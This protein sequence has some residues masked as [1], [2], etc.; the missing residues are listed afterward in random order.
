MRV[1]IRFFL[2]AT[3]LSAA[4]VSAGEQEGKGLALMSVSPWN[5]TPDVRELLVENGYK[6]KNAAL[7]Y[8]FFHGISKLTLGFLDVP[9]PKFWPEELEADWRKGISACTTRVGDGGFGPKNPV[10]V[11]CA[12]ELSQAL[13]RRFVEFMQPKIVIVL[14]LPV[15][16]KK[17]AKLRAHI[18]GLQDRSCRSLTETDLTPENYE[19]TAIGMVRALLKGKGKITPLWTKRDLPSPSK[20]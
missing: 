13:W 10:A 2:M 17:G 4:A 15:D 12:Q 5:F 11:A 3:I 14:S 16:R 19:K 20:Q 18:Y 9:M 6:V 8:D 1:C 7:E